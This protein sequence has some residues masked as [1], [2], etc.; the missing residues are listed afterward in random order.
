MSRLRSLPILHIISS[1]GRFDATGSFKTL[2]VFTLLVFTPA[3][4]YT[5]DNKTTVTTHLLPDSL[6]GPLALANASQWGLSCRIWA[7]IL[8][9]WWKHLCCSQV[10][11][12]L[13][14]S[15]QR[16]SGPRFSTEHLFQQSIYLLGQ[17]VKLSF[18]RGNGCKGRG[19]T[20]KS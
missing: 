1:A 19:K 8:E 15:N 13:I 9:V 3:F 11:L 4:F 5:E 20:R 16:H 6:L 10:F 12:K 2:W 14:C 17:C 18:E 7:F